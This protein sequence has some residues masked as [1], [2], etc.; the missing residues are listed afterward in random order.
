M[1]GSAV[2]EQVSSAE[3]RETAGAATVNDPSELQL[4]VV[5]L[6]LSAAPQGISATSSAAR[7]DTEEDGDAA[8]ALEWALPSA[9]AELP[10]AMSWPL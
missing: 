4:S 2:H 6:V 1:R 7:A 8:A 5:E 3:D 10:V 9:S